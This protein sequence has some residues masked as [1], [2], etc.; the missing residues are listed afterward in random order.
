MRAGLEG[1]AEIAG[2]LLQVVEGR[3]IGGK[4]DAKRVWPASAGE[5]GVAANGEAEL[6]RIGEAVA[7]ISGE[8]AV[9]ERVVDALAVGME[10]GAGNGVVEFVRGG[11]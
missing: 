10:V 6:I 2:K 3:R 11:R 5:T 9:E 1:P 7:E 8:A 4:T